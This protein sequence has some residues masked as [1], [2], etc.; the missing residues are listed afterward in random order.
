MKARRRFKLILASLLI[1]CL[2][3]FF[4]S[5]IEAFAP[6][7]KDLAILKIEDTFNGKIKLS[8]GSLDGGILHPIVLNGIKI[9]DSRGVLL[10]SSVDIA[11]IS[12]NYHIWD[13]FFKRHDNSAISHILG[14]DSC[15]YVNFSAKNNK[16]AGFVKL[17]GDLDD[18]RLKGYVNFAGSERMDFTGRIKQN[19]FDL[20][21]KLAGGSFSAQCSISETGE[22]VANIKTSRFS[23]YGLDIACDAVLKS[24]IA[25]TRGGTRSYAEGEFEIKNLIINDDPSLGVKAFYRMTD[26]LL[27][28]TDINFGGGLSG[29]GNIWLKSPF[30]V[31]ALLLANNVNLNRL[32]LRLGAKDAGSVLSG[33]LNGRLEV[34]GVMRNLKSNIHLEIRK[35]TLS[36]LNFDYLNANLKGDGPLLRIE[37]SKITRES[38]YFGLTGEMDLR[39]IGRASLFEQLKL[40]S[41]DRAITWDG[42]NSKQVQD[43]QEFSMKKRINDDIDLNFRKFVNDV[44]IDESLRDT[45]EVQL[46]YKLHSNSSLKMVVG[47][48]KDFFGFEHK[49]KF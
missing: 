16:A 46:D 34:K 11:S 9:K 28:I 33:M 21:A 20:D 17:D 22:L 47:Q 2:A 14:R 40:S 39:K 45:D 24:R 26:S 5:R 41:D 30:N 10:F 7:I 29:R 44:K 13:A 31:D 38:G 42:W 36:T 43:V 12:T 49:D 1:I 23:L 37:D 3:L 35:G 8:I 4:E 32:F 19:R 18:L 6:Q 27:E 25:A 48:N 15:V